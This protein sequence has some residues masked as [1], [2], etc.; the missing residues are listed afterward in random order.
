MDKCTVN[1][2]GVR[3]LKNTKYHIEYV[4]FDIMFLPDSALHSIQLL[5]LTQIAIIHKPEYFSNNTQI[6]K[7]DNCIKINATLVQKC[8]ITLIPDVILRA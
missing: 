4:L 8:I 5:D 6:L 7:N 3:I 2:R 1:S